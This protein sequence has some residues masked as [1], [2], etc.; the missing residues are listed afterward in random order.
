MYVWA[1]RKE[2]TAPR[3]VQ[4]VR[5]PKLASRDSPLGREKTPVR[6]G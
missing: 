5:E 4:G 6:E 3:K 1:S 2:G